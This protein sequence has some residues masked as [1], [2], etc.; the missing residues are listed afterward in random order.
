MQIHIKPNDNSVFRPEII[1][2]LTT[3]KD[4]VM[5]SLHGFLSVS[6]IKKKV[7]LVCY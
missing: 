4:S 2:D 5:F 1:K 6:F 3:G 7:N